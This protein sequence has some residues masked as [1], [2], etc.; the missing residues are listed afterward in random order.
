MVLYGASDGAQAAV[1]TATYLPHLADAVVASSPTDIIHD[2]AGG[3]G[4]GWTFGGKPLEAGMLIPVTKI[5]V[6]LLMG[7]GGQDAV[8]DSA[9]S[10]SAIVGELDRSPG[11]APVTNFYYPGA[12]HY[13]FGM[14]P[15]YP[16]F[17][18]ASLG[19]T[20]QANALATEQFWTRMTAFLN[21][22]T[23]GS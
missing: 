20:A 13:Y 8:W 22:L 9:G 23:A 10:A 3:T 2:A 12:G 21:H 1:L 19:G 14:S 18:N 17:T 11:H 4:P 5:R 7:D 15:Y 16:F 6:P